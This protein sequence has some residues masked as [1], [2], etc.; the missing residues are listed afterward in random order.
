[1]KRTINAM[2]FLGI[3][4]TMIYS[5]NVI[6]SDDFESGTPNANWEVFYGGEDALQAVPMSQA[7]AALTGGGDY[8][9]YLQDVDASYTGIAAAVAGDLDL[10]DYTIDADV[11]CYVSEPGGSAYTGV[12][13][14]A[15]SSL[16][17]SASHGFMYKLVADFDSD[18]RLRLYNNQFSTSTYTYTFDEAIDATGLYS[19]NGWHHMKLVVN[20][21]DESTTTFTCYFDGALVGSDTYTDTGVDQVSHGKFGLFATQMDNDGIP[22]YFD[23]IVVTENQS[24]PATLFSDDFESGTP[25]TDWEVFYGGEDALQAVPMSQAPAALTG[26]GDYVGYLQDVDASYTGIAAAVAGDLDLQDY[27]IDADVYCYVSEPGGSAYTGVV[28]YADSSLQGSASH[29]FMYKLVADFDSDNRLRLYNNQFSTSTYTYTFD[30]AIDATGL[31]SGN[32]W[33]H[34]KLVVNS[35]DEST[36]TFTCY[37]DGALVGSDTYTDTGVDQVSH[38]KF[39]LFATQMDNDGIPGYF[40]NIVVTDN[41][42][43]SVDPVDTPL[44]P[45]DFSLEQ[46]YPN[47]FNPTTTI[48]FVLGSDQIISLDVYNLQG[49]KVKTLAEGL[50]PAHRYSIQWNG[51]NEA[52]IK[53]PSGVYIYSLR[54]GNQM[55][56]KKMILVK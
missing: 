9:G 53:V 16:Q 43:V 51:R 8:V 46:N 48:N 7:P 29:G 35:P 2:L 17:G 24:G 12:V 11:Y 3:V 27:T 5:Q 49:Q 25:N 40:D 31:Y 41:G 20:S 44:L 45:T 33:H 14:Y 32:G 42:T 55:L 54:N 22:G 6:F 26:G 4:S 39:G 37:F 36:T 1:M 13:V 52:G 28:V 50:L 38:G 19:G 18:N 21:P 30:E 23:N 15:D 56:S 47:P 10:Q 34:M